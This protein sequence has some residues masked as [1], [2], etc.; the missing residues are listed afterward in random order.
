MKDTFKTKI[1]NFFKENVDLEEKSFIMDA[2][3][4]ILLEKNN[5]NSTDSSVY[6]KIF[7]S[8]KSRKHYGTK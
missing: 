8:K 1:K 3:N 6:F 4:E 5:K 7:I 2:H